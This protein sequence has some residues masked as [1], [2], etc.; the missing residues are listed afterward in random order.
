MKFVATKTAEQLDLQATSGRGI[1]WSCN[2][3]ISPI[4]LASSSWSS[5]FAVRQGQGFFRA[6]LPRVLVIH[7]D[8][9]SCRMVRLT[10]VLPEDLDQRIID[11]SGEIE[12]HAQ[13]DAGRGWSKSVSDIG[14][15]VCSPMV[16]AIGS[17]ES[18]SKNRDFAG[19]TG[20]L[21]H[22]A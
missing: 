12:E 21:E 1:D 9:L 2:V 15:I 3:P 19:P 8:V 11:L 4:K 7:L 13:R 18:F 20:M 6:K 17:G 10:E 14:P 5:A 16:A 22:L